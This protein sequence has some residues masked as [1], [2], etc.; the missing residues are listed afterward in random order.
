MHTGQVRLK[1]GRRGEKLTRQYLKKR[2]YRLL[3]SNY[4]TKQGEIDLIM[5]QD[6]TIVF[7]EVKTRQ[8]AGSVPGEE[9]VNYI[10]Q[11]HIA[12][13]AREF[14]HLHK[15]FDYPCRFDIVAVEVPHKGKPVIQHW[16]NAFVPDRKN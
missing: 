15:L 3:Q 1:L 6:E 12:A 2:G 8:G 10:K 13:A 7:V 16:E 14:I 11:R 9:A 4:T 5:R